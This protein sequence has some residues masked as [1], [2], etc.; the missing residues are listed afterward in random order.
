MPE[1]PGRFFVFFTHLLVAWALP[2]A[3]DGLYILGNGRGCLYPL[4]FIYPYAFQHL[5]P[6]CRVE[7]NGSRCHRQAACDTR[8]QNNL[9]EQAIQSTVLASAFVCFVNDDQIEHAHPEP[10]G[11]FEAWTQVCVAFVCFCCQ[12]TRPRRGCYQVIQ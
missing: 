6:L 5:G 10:D 7:F 4:P 9:I 2:H 1:K 11:T 8:L 3:G 12:R